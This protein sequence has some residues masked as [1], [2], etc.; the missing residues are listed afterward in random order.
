MTE[1]RPK[2]STPTKPAPGVK[3]SGLE[4][5]PVKDLEPGESQ[6]EDV[7][8]GFGGT[9]HVVPGLPPRVSDATFKAQ[10]LPLKNALVRLSAFR[11]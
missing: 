6:S 2:P 11:F 3:K 9:E 7:R 4:A 8:G 5:E 10:V 1:S